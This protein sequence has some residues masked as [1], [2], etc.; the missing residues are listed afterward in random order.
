M[1]LFREKRQTPTNSGR[2]EKERERKRER[3]R[4]RNQLREHQRHSASSDSVVEMIETGSFSMKR[5][6]NKASH[7]TTVVMMLSET[8]AAKDGGSE[9][10]EQRIAN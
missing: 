5:Q 7:C 3:E 6:R 2:V 4:E 9:R 1:A 10:S 8:L